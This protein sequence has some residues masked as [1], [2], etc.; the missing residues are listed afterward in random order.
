ME[1]SPVR[2]KLIFVDEQPGDVEQFQ[3]YIKRKDEDRFFEVIPIIPPSDIEE[4]IDI[5]IS[6]NPSAVISDFRLNEF[7]PDVTYNGV[8][9]V[10]AVLEKKKDFPCF[11]LTSF[12]D[13][14]AQQSEDVN[15]IYIKELM[16]DSKSESEAKISFYGRIRLQ[17]QKY[18]AKLVLSE[19]IIK[20]LEKTRSERPLTSSE[21]QQYIDSNVLL[22]RYTDN[23]GS[24]P[25]AFYHKDTNDLLQ[26][27]ISRADDLIN[28]L[29]EEKN[30]Q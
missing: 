7:K 8:D 17:I 6:F 26:T 27:I 25:R 1:K 19:D 10:N 16:N 28:K 30:E 4:L 13:S 18:K 2:E 11:V 3:R 9:V 5:I 23:S 20:H 29:K 12:D 21:E 15:I 22:D 24:L 14:A